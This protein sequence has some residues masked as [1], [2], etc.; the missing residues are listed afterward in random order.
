MSTYIDFVNTSGDLVT[1]NIVYQN[2]PSENT[3]FN[4]NNGQTRKQ[5][6]PYIDSAFPVAFILNVKGD[7]TQFPLLKMEKQPNSTVRFTDF[8]VQP[9]PIV[10]DRAAFA[11]YKYN[12]DG[13]PDD[14]HIEPFYNTRSM[15]EK[16]EVCPAGMYYDGA[17]GKCGK[18]EF[19]PYS[20]P[21]TNQKLSQP[22]VRKN[23]FQL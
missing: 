3:S 23:W 1:I 22:T 5:T 19:V 10:K 21:T 9:N 16:Y 12:V 18:F 15:R 20:A 14:F 6:I 8:F 4:L 17:S 11:T 13:L 7:S 2:M